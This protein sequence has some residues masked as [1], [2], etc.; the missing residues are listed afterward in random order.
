MNK[1]EHCPGKVENNKIIKLENGKLKPA[2]LNK[3]QKDKMKNPMV[4]NLKLITVANNAKNK[5]N[6]DTINHLTPCCKINCSPL[7]IKRKASNQRSTN[8]IRLICQ[9]IQNQ[10]PNT[11]TKI[12]QPRIL[13]PPSAANPGKTAN[14]PLAKTPFNQQYTANTNNPMPCPKLIL[15]QLLCSKYC[16][17][18][19]MLRIWLL[20]NME[21]YFFS[22]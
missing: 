21:Q 9:I 22:V 13:N 19:V 15:T 4:N 1:I 6:S 11:P 5:N 2:K 20:T 7:E 14:Q 10:I 18:E 3:G 17:L 12:T 16:Q 8:H